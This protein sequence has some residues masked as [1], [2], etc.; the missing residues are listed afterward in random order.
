MTLEKEIA[1]LKSQLAGYKEAIELCNF[2][3]KQDSRDLR[4]AF[5]IIQALRKGLPIDPQRINKWIMP[6]VST[7]F[8]KG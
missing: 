3:R 4:E 8:W 7:G 2:Y 1:K 5:E 6:F